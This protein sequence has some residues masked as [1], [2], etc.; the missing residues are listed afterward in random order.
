MS[1]PGSHGMR[2]KWPIVA[3]VLSALTALISAAAMRDHVRLVEIV[4]LFASGV[5]TG[6]SITALV[7]GRARARD[8]SS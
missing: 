3:T 7:V 2:Q 4:S 1:I 5:A 6:A 8:V